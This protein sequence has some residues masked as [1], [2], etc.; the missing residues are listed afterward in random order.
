MK[1]SRFRK[2][3][4]IVAIFSASLPTTAHALDRST[5]DA[6]LPKDAAQSAPLLYIAKAKLF[7]KNKL[8]AR[9]FCLIEFR[10]TAAS[11]E[12]YFQRDVEFVG[13]KTAEDIQKGVEKF[14]VVI[15]SV[16]KNVVRTQDILKQ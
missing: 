14:V 4:P 8:F 5:K 2:I 11:V 3:C 7:E 16:S 15:A 6:C 12:F 9:Q 10:V 13:G 1:L